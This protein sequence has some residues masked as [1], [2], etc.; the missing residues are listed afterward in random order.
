MASM[1]LLFQTTS[2]AILALLDTM[3]SKVNDH[4]TQQTQLRA[5]INAKADSSEIARLDRHMEDMAATVATTVRDGFDATLGLTINKALDSILDLKANYSICQRSSP[6][7]T[8]PPRPNLMRCLS[9]R[10]LAS[11]NLH[12]DMMHASRN[13]ASAQEVPL[14]IL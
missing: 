1:M 3:D 8:P 2:Q 11:M 9:T 5:A 4:N 13:W 7:W 14:L 10:P 6:R 12:R